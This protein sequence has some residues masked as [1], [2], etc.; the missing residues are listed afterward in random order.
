[1]TRPAVAPEIR[2]WRQVVR[3]PESNCW[4]WIGDAHKRDHHGRFTVS[5]TG[6]KP[7]RVMAYR[8]SYE[9]MVGPIPDGMQLDHFR[10]EPLCVNPA[11]LEPV[12]G[13]E[14]QHRGN[15][16]GG[17][18]FRKTHCPAGHPLS[19]DNLIAQ[20]GRRYCRACRN[21]QAREYGARKRKANEAA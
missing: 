21:Q 7:Y 10:C 13:K 1:M 12:T 9:Q 6:N 14:N 18:N 8:W 15:G 17:V 4:I 3:V 2:F 11:H 5:S 16:L 20:R 19:G